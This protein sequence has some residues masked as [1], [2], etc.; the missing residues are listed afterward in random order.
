MGVSVL[1]V[2]KALLDM[3]VDELKD[4]LDIPEVAAAS[5]YDYISKAQTMLAVEQAIAILEYGYGVKE[6]V[7][8]L[9]SLY[10]SIKDPQLRD[11]CAD[12]L[13]SNSKFDRVINQATLVLEDRIRKKVGGSDLTGT[14]LANQFIKSDATSSP[15]VFSTD[16][17]EQKGY[18][19]LVRGVFL[20]LRNGTHHQ[21][22]DEFSRE[23]AFAICAFIDRL[24]RLL[25]VASFRK[26]I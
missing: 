3:G 8:E 11:R 22:S 1:A 16:G 23:D 20:A 15:I 2:L 17:D 24:L 18:A 7:V 19:D 14:R 9:G 21:I 10:N 5:N 25:E 6:Q 4:L 12:L 13:A 26:D